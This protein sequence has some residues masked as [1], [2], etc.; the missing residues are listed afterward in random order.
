MK[1]K[2]KLSYGVSKLLFSIMFS[3]GRQVTEENVEKYSAYEKVEQKIADV[4]M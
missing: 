2:Y 3:Y 4:K 1:L